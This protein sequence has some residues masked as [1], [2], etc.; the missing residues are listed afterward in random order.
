MTTAFA[1]LPVHLLD[2]ARPERLRGLDEDAALPVV[3]EV[4][5]RGDPPRVARDVVLPPE[6]EPPP[7]VV[8]RG[9]DP[10]ATPDVPDDDAD[11]NPPW[12]RLTD[13]R[14]RIDFL[15]QYACFDAATF[16][17]LATF[18]SALEPRVFHPGEPLVLQ[19]QECR[20]MFLI[21]SGA[22][23]VSRRLLLRAT[24]SADPWSDEAVA[25]DADA[26]PA[27]AAA[28]FRD[29]D[30]RLA[31]LR[32]VRERVGAGYRAFDEKGA[33]EDARLCVDAEVRCVG[34]FGAVGGGDCVD[35]SP[36][37]H[38]CVARGKKPTLAMFAPYR[39]VA[40]L[41]SR[42]AAN[43]D[44]FRRCVAPVPRAVDDAL[45]EALARLGAENRREKKRVAEVLRS[46]V[47]EILRRSEGLQRS[48]VP[49]GLARGKGKEKAPARASAASRFSAA[50]KTRSSADAR[51]VAAFLREANAFAE[52]RPSDEANLAA[53]EK[54]SFVASRPR[55][56]GGGGGVV[57][58]WL[59]VTPPPVPGSTYEPATVAVLYPSSGRE[60]AHVAG[61]ARG[62]EI[63]TR[64][65]R[66]RLGL[67]P[68]ERLEKKTLEDRLARVADAL[69]RVGSRLGSGFLGAASTASHAS[70]ASFGGGHSSA[71]L[72]RGDA[73]GGDGA[74]I[75]LEREREVLVAAFRIVTR[76]DDGSASARGDASAPL[77]EGTDANRANDTWARVRDEAFAIGARNAAGAP[78]GE[79]AAFVRWSSDEF[80][81]IARVAKENTTAVENTAVAR[82]RAARRVLDLALELSETVSALSAG[83]ERVAVGVASGGVAYVETIESAARAV[84]GAPRDEA[85]ALCESAA[86]AAEEKGAVFA[87]D[88]VRAA[89]RRT[90]E[91]V[92]RTD[93]TA[94][95]DGNGVRAAVWRVAGANPA[96][97]PGDPGAEAVVNPTSGDRAFA[98]AA[99]TTGR[100]RDESPGRRSSRGGN[101]T[102]GGT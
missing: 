54:S 91:F 63:A 78:E 27:E 70:S 19:G 35:R 51:R 99:K 13:V 48:S 88:A 56:G 92:D 44:R 75:G 77:E 6:S 66:V 47:P 53:E 52:R 34:A 62:A 96:L 10:G 59:G 49:E 89:C 90:H 101:N 14:S 21:V 26:A 25:R 4:S 11:A 30:Q 87:T 23:S 98:P 3:R 71:Y 43:A 73:G 31:Y 74:R 76:A 58:G 102:S 7:P 68:A 45:R 20:G 5:P 33:E 84:E 69:A 41:L 97:E 17:E 61:V 50:P 83:A 8:E 18:A 39:D 72:G 24:A 2:E 82:T 64:R 60:D 55:R 37:A 57:N 65:E 67:P 28:L 29:R 42:S 38:H 36:A 9:G 40:R 100:G 16:A 86:A 12:P 79:A 94:G 46:E 93:R 81:A 95:A 32:R 80:L 85:A 15:C 1:H 22:V